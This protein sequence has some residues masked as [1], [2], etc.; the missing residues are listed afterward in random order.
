MGVCWLFPA[1]CLRTC[2]RDCFCL[3]VGVGFWCLGLLPAL[4]RELLMYG[5]AVLNGICTTGG[6]THALSV[7]SSQWAISPQIPVLSF[8][9]QIE[10]NEII[11]ISEGRRGQR[12]LFEWRVTSLFWGHT[13]QYSG[14]LPAYAFR[15]Y[16][17]QC[18][19]LLGVCVCGG[20]IWDAVAWTWIGIVQLLF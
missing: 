2:T 1:Q 19:W 14:V 15:N 9:L 20:T 6:W 4:T 12:D 5:P 17:W 10:S 18:L 7:H 11:D 8:W 13:R 3:E 16:T